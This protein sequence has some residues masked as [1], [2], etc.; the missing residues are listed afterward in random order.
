MKWLQNRVGVK[1]PFPKYFQVMVPWV[2]GAM[3]NISLVTWDSVFLLDKKLAVEWKWLVDSIVLHECSHS[4]FGDALVIRHF[5][6]GS[7]LDEF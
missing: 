5:E 6:H 3:E 1:F 2:G 7:F 4:Y